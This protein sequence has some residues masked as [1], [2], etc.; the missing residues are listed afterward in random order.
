MLVKIF[1]D[2]KI[3]LIVCFLKCVRKLEAKLNCSITFF[4]S[5]WDEI[6]GHYFGMI[7]RKFV[8]I[9]R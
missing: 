2:I 3:D 7:F 1:E 9:F 4:M 5:V 6:L 8:M